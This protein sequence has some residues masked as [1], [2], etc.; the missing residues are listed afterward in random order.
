MRRRRAPRCARCSRCS[1]AWPRPTPRCSSRARA[2]PARSSSRARSTSRSRRSTGPF[3]AINCAAMPETL[4]ESELFGHV[5]GAFTDARTRRRGL[6]VEA[7][8]GTLF[9]DEIG[10]MPLGMQAK[11]LRALQERA[12]RPVGGDAE[13]PFDARLIAATNRDLE[14]EVD[15]R[16]LPRGPL[17]PHQRRARRAAAAARAR[18]RRPAPGAAPPRRAALRMGKRVTGMSPRG[19]QAPRVRVARQRA[20][21]A[22]LH[23]ARGRA[24]AL[25]AARRRR[26]PG[27]RSRA[28][29]RAHVARRERR[30]RGAPADGRGRAPLHPARPP[31]GRRQQDAR[32]RILGLDRKTLYRRLDAYGVSGREAD[33]K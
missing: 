5:K 26:S 6:F 15:E 1:T 30:S 12:V 31:S 24:R 13:V 19:R 25:R 16:P 9:L 3:V 28:T 32:A 4:L 14:A 8:G 27:A 7:S 29:A 2:E 21:A 17:L 22:E 23:R 18:R 11:L 33:D 20:R 10:E